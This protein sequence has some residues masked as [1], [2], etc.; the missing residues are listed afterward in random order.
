M[1]RQEQLLQVVERDID[2]DCLDYL[3]LRDLMQT[4]HRKLLAREC[5]QVELLNERISGLLE[6]VKARAQRRSKILTAF[7][8]G[9][10]HEAMQRL[11]GLFDEPRT[12][13]LCSQWQQL[14]QIVGQCKRLNENNG[15]LLAM[16]HDILDQLLGTRRDAQLYAP[17]YY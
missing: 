14:G 11:L 5:A 2:Q 12:Q 8:L 1:S 13:R 17:Q 9:D 7:A 15:T 4:L 6:Q 10:G 16:Q 3:Q